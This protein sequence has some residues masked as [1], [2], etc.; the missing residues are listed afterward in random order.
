[1]N[2]Y[3]QLIEE[4][5][6]S[7]TTA[8]YCPS[9]EYVASRGFV[10]AISLRKFISA[11]MKKGLIPSC[12]VKLEENQYL[13]STIIIIEISTYS[14]DNETEL[15]IGS[16]FKACECDSDCDV[17]LEG[18]DEFRKSI[19]FLQ[20][21]LVLCNDQ[22][23]LEKL[24]MLTMNVIYDGYGGT[25]W[26]VSWRMSSLINTSTESW[27][28]VTQA[29]EDLTY[30]PWLNTSSQYSVSGNEYNALGLNNTTLFDYIQSF[31][32]AGSSSDG[33]DDE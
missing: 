21:L 33:D 28:L 15:S 18:I 30:A 9:P 17:S 31:V 6:K 24:K 3:G 32:G 29:V 5:Y 4:I 7:I 26:V 16:S 23:G 20:L 2:N 14:Y 10:N 22:E 27:N 1:M 25:E 11:I 12:K 8:N 13:F 19:V